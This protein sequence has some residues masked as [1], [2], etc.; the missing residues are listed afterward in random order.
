MIISAGVRSGS[1]AH[2][3]IQIQLTREGIPFALFKVI[4]QDLGDKTINVVHAKGAPVR[5]KGDN[6]R[7]AIFFSFLEH[8]MKFLLF[9]EIKQSQSE[10]TTFFQPSILM[11]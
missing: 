7:H 4:G 6:V 8:T 9:Q 2:K 1:H 3:A 5:Q 11:S 10:W